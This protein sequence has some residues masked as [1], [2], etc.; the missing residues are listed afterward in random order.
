MKQQEKKLVSS[1]QSLYRNPVGLINIDIYVGINRELLT[2][3]SLEIDRFTRNMVNLLSR[4]TLLSDPETKSDI[5]KHYGLLMNCFDTAI[6]A[7][8][9]PNEYDSESIEPWYSVTTY[10]GIIKIG[11]RKRVINID[12]TLSDIEYNGRELF[13]SE[14]VTKDD[15]FIHACSYEKAKEYIDKLLN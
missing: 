12:W 6:Y 2:D 3:E 11:W 8:K 5:D 9:I 14:D 15:K 13:A 7:K 10:K 1:I 4:N